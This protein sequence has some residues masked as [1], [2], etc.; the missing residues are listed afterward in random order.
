MLQNSFKK[1]YRGDDK[2]CTLIFILLVLSIGGDRDRAT[3]IFIYM[4]LFWKKNG[5]GI[6]LDLK[7][8]AKVK[9]WVWV[10]IVPLVN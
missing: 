7:S 6:F 9:G 8:Q 10:E 4:F 3:E 1:G 2:F 5:L